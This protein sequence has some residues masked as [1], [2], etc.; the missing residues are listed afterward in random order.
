M[1][2]FSKHHKA[3]TT[4]LMFQCMLMALVVIIIVPHVIELVN[5]RTGILNT[6]VTSYISAVCIVLGVLSYLVGLIGLIC[7]VLKVK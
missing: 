4:K 3:L 5:Y 2:V 6:V 1:I 7:S